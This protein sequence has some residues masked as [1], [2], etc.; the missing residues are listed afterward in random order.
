[1]L[2]NK[3]FHIIYCD[4]ACPPHSVV[5]MPLGSKKSWEVAS[6]EKRQVTCLRLF[7]VLFADDF[8]NTTK[9]CTKEIRK[10]KK[11]V[12]C[13]YFLHDILVIIVKCRLSD[14]FTLDLMVKFAKAVKTWLWKIPFIHAV[15][16]AVSGWFYSRVF[17]VEILL[18]I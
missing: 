17:Q 6:T 8:A 7:L 13:C 9:P 12:W 11:K 3:D 1:M 4:Y 10:R 2:Q 5:L 18:R 16:F 15:F 14:N